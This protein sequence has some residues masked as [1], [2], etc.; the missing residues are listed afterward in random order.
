MGNGGRFTRMNDNHRYFHYGIYFESFIR[1]QADLR[2]A[3]LR[4]DTLLS[5]GL[6]SFNVAHRSLSLTPLR[7]EDF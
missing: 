5:E 2:K 6:N 7:H 4:K 3:D 1:D